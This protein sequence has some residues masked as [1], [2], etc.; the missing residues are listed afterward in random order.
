M[1]NTYWVEFEW[2]YKILLDGKWEEEKST[3]SCRFHTPKKRLKKEVENYVREEM[4]GENYNDLKTNITN[5]YM[6][7]D[8]EI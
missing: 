6:T 3:H 4:E 5:V 8:Y 7:T 1:T 2:H